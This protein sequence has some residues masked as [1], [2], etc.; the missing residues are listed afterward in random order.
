MNHWFENSRRNLT[1]LSKA[2]TFVEALKEWVFTGSTIEC[3]ENDG[4]CQLC[5]HPELSYYF[6]IENAL[7]SKRMLVGSKC[8]L[9]FQE[10]NVLDKEG[11]LLTDLQGR[12]GALNDALRRNLIECSLMPLRKLWKKDK[13]HR[14][15]ITFLAS[16]IKDQVGLSPNDLL[17][18]FRGMDDHGIS[19]VVKHYSVRLRSNSQ[20]S[21]IMRMSR[22]SLRKISPALSTEQKARV[23][24]WRP[25]KLI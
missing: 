5:E 10:I 21:E 19:Y 20:Q 2:S 8:I 14:N 15:V 6:E 13:E 7:T 11:I 12:K 25:D 24:K 18:L 9:K 23:R 3:D 22:E 1:P 4:T 16:Q 17:F